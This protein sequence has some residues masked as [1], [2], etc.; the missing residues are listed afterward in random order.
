M[1]P[2]LIHHGDKIVLIF[3]LAI[4]V[5][6]PIHRGFRLDGGVDM[7]AKVPVAAASSRGGHIEESRVAHC[8]SRQSGVRMC[9]PWVEK[10]PEGPQK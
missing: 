3:A 6:A 4:F 8:E 7:A 1:E 2:L 10:G 5:V 9:E